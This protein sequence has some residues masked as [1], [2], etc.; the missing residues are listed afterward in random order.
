M[1][2]VIVPANE[3][4]LDVTIRNIYIFIGGFL[5]QIIIDDLRFNIKSIF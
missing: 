5:I 1:A 2:N 3:A 4:L